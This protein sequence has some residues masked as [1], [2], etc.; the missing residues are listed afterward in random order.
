MAQCVF[1]FFCVCLTLNWPGESAVCKHLAPPGLC[2]CVHWGVCVV[3]P[4]RC[5]SQRLPPDAG[6]RTDDLHPAGLCL[7]LP[8]RGTSPDGKPQGLPP[9]HSHD[10][11]QRQ[12]GF[13]E[14]LHS[15]WGKWLNHEKTSIFLRKPSCEMLLT[16]PDVCF[17]YLVHD[18]WVGHHVYVEMWPYWHL[19]Q[20]AGS[21]GKTADFA[22]NLLID[23]IQPVVS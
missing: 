20:P 12:H 19:K 6:P 17:W 11:V 9:Q 8:V 18:V 22:Q 21:S 14:R 15:V 4:S 13:T 23:L 3:A 16:A 5:P 1:F 2:V 10:R 7:L